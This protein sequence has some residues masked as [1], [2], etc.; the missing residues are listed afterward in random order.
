MYFSGL[1]YAIFSL[2]FYDPDIHPSDLSL[3]VPRHEEEQ[4]ERPDEDK[5]LMQKVAELAG[6][7]WFDEDG[8]CG[9]LPSVDVAN[10]TVDD[11]ALM[12]VSAGIPG[13]VRYVPAGW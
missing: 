9:T 12:M 11:A 1:T 5:M 6:G 13:G 7:V 10:V 8:K 4:V 2:F 3:L